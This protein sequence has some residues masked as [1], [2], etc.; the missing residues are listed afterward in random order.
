MGII[1][2]SKKELLER[3]IGK[4]KSIMPIDCHVA[5]WKH[6]SPLTYDALSVF[7]NN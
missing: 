2:K 6:F 5:I 3:I 7:I 1:G 4:F